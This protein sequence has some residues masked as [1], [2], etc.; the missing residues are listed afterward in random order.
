MKICFLISEYVPHQ[1]TVIK[2]LL[3]LDA[4]VL[5]FSYD[6]DRTRVPD[7]AN[8]K[9][10]NAAY[11]TKT[12]MIK[13]ITAFNPCIII[14]AGWMF[15]KYKTVAKFFKSRK[16]VKTVAYSDTPWYGR[17]TQRI[18][19]LISPLYLKRMFDYIWV[20]GVRQY[21]Y[22]RKLKYDNEHIIFNCLTADTTLFNQV[23]L[24]NKRKTYPRRIVFVGRFV[25][26][27]GLKFLIEAWKNIKNKNGWTLTLIGEGPLQKN[28]L[29]KGDKDLFF[30]PFLTQ[31]EI[32]KEFDHTGC[33]VLPS[34]KESW[35]LVLHEAA[36]AGLPIICTRTC[37]ATPHFVIN[38]YN[39]Y[40]VEEKSIDQ[41]QEALEKIIQKTEDELV[42]MSE[43]SRELGRR[44]SPSISVGSLLQIIE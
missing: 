12:E 32:V 7:F 26:E 25:E 29:E 24:F 43:R 34:I 27:K 13:T 31:S 8:F 18:N 5:V 21:D 6:K 14:T 20:A 16:G 4:K 35:A 38:N 2:S 40:V 44:I 17:L 41:L 30:K 3:D 42:L 15:S 39:G 10:Y 11:T 33:F 36:I 9:D 1:L 37:G 22:A 28:M 23:N 19:C